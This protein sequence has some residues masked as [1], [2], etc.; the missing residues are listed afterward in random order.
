MGDVPKYVN[1]SCLPTELQGTKH[2]RTDIW[3]TSLFCVLVFVVK[4]L[5]MNRPYS[6][7]QKYQ[8]IPINH[9]IYE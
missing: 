1:E 5:I 4:Y 7:D 2:G 9:T 6:K 8:F 3:V